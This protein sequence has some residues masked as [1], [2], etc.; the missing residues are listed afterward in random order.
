MSDRPYGEKLVRD[1]I[2][3]IIQAEGREAAIRPVSD[4]EVAPYVH[5]KVLEELSQP[6]IYKN[7]ADYRAYA[8]ELIAEQQ[9]LIQKLG[10]GAR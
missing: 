10:L 1:G 8:M 6:Y 3:A 5:R 4:A 9:D 7:S 2:P